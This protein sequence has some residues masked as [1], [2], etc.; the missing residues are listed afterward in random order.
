MVDQWGTYSLSTCSGDILI[1]AKV[2]TFITSIPFYEHGRLLLIG[3]FS[4][5]NLQNYRT[6]RI[7]L[8]I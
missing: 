7:G 3:T 8:Y 4:L 6:S 2:D 1:A 5:T